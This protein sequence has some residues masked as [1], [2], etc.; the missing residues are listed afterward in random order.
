MNPRITILREQ[1]LAVKPFI[2]I[3][4]AKLITEAYQTYQGKVP[5][6][7]LRALVFKHLLENKTITIEPDE[8]I[9]G[10]RGSSPAA[11][12]TYPE[13][14]CHTLEDFDIIE[15]RE[16]ISFQVSPEA[17]KIQK[18]VIIPFWQERSIRHQ[19]FSL[20]GQSWLDSYEA[21]I[22]T[23]FMEQTEGARSYRS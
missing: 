9:V 15:Q 2:D 19:L 18:E 1:S 11:T 23:E 17:R 5:V 4:R 21:G 14:C 13:L 20:M 16:R 6:P 10:E 3:E 8:L 22:F 7:I 12:P